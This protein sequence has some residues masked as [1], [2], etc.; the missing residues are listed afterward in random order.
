MLSLVLLLIILL[1]Y[2]CLRGVIMKQS[3]C[4]WH[5][6]M[7]EHITIRKGAALGGCMKANKKCEWRSFRERKKVSPKPKVKRIQ[8]VPLNDEF[9]HKRKLYFV[10]PRGQR[11]TFILIRAHFHS[12]NMKASDICCCNKHAHATG[13][14]VSH[15]DN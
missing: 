5:T 4:G 3:G 8:S 6:E 9:H 15:F 11:L 12:F 7:K 10:F 1:A 14:R 13:A 2:Y